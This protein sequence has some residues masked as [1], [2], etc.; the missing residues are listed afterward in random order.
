[1]AA[2]TEEH[3]DV[4]N[5]DGSKTGRTAPRSQVHSEG[6]FHKAVHV[7]LWSPSTD[8]L[9]L[10]MR[11][12]CKDSW[13]GRLDISCAGH[14]S[15]GQDSLP[16]AE[17]ELEEE[18]GLSFSKERFEFLFTHLELLSSVQKGKPF[19]NN[20]FNDLYLITLTDEE[21]KAL[22]PALS[23]CPFKLQ[24][25]EV[26]GVEWTKRSEVIRMYREKDPKIV[27]CSDLEGS[28]IQLFHEIEKRMNK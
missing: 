2:V 17:R 20:E 22:D 6:L 12:D 25:E 10:Q 19:I 13:P 21:R 16:A 14:L 18:L 9:L 11:A 28:Y 4:L 7:W 8:E 26:S 3:F 5:R 15:A 1:M 23:P 27:P 24:P